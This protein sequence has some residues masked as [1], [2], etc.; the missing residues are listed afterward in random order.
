[1]PTSITAVVK[2]IAIS[3][4]LAQTEG[5]KF[6]LQVVSELRNRGGKDIL[7]AGV[8]G[9]RGFPE[10]RESVFPQTPFSYASY[11]WCATA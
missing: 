7:I 11:T 10:A 2:R 5:A 8:E 1:M 4:W 9:L 3:P 6:W